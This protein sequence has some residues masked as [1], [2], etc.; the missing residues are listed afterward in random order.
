MVSDVCDSTSLIPEPASQVD[1][2]GRV[3]WSNGRVLRL[4]ADRYVGFYRDLIANTHIQSLYDRGLVSTMISPTLVNGYQLV[5]EHRRIPIVSYAP[6]WSSEMLKDAML[7]LLDLNAELLKHG[8]TLKDAHPYNILF[9]TTV[10]QFV[11]WGSIC[12]VDSLQ[13]WPYLEFRGRMLLPWMLIGAGLGKIARPLLLDTGYQLLLRDALPLL[14]SRNPTLRLLHF[15]WTD[16][17]IRRSSIRPSSELFAA[18]RE[19]VVSIKP[20]LS[21]AE[22]TSYLKLEGALGSSGDWVDKFRNVQRILASLRPET[23]L[24]VECGEGW[25]S[26]LAVQ[27]GARVIAVDTDESGVDELYHR[28]RAR[29]LPIL[30]LI[31]DIWCPTPSHGLGFGLPPAVERLHAQLV[32][33]LN[34]TH[35]L[36][37]K[38]GYSFDLIAS[39]LARFTDRWLV[40]EFVPAGDPSIREWVTPGHSWYHLEGFIQSLRSHFATI[41]VIPSSPEP[42]VLL[43]CDRQG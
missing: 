42:R 20:P 9:D 7:L 38:R 36:A 29:R 30:P 18:L 21:K 17:A 8:L 39:Q 15:V 2:V 31:L 14:L 37:I 12:S 34:A 35:R 16:R 23:V 19:I 24:D 27:E 41:E 43:V 40:V 33:S 22:R 10:P 3:V 26:E 11:D 32:L 4:I 25:F 1:D 6:E 5:L 28:A 13:H